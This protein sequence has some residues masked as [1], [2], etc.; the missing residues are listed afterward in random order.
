MDNESAQSNRPKRQRI[1]KPTEEQAPLLPMGES[2][3]A[4]SAPVALE[5]TAPVKP[6]RNIRPRKGKPAAE[7]APIEVDGIIEP[8]EVDTSFVT[9]DAPL[10]ADKVSP[11]DAPVDVN[12]LPKED[13][14]AQAHQHQHRQHRNNYNQVIKELDG[15]IDNEGVLEIMQEGGYGF[16]RSSD[17]NYLASPDDIYVSPSQIKMFGRF[18]LRKKGRNILPC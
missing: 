7:E 8:E 6:A 12:T 9:S 4:E 17:Y 2:P 14:P 10:A 11:T 15:L 1:Q 3:V 5:E 13:A 16:M 18:A